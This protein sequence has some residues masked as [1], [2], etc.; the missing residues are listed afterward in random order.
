MK[1]MLLVFVVIFN[2][3]YLF[4]QT[5][6]YNETKTFEESD[7]T[8]KADVHSWGEIYLYNASN[9]WIGKKQVYKSTGKSFDFLNESLDY[10]DH[11]SWLVGKENIR[12]ILNRTLSRDEKRMIGDKE[13]ILNMYVN[14]TTGKIDDVCFDFFEDSP[15]RFIPISIYRK[16]ELDIKQNIQLTLTD[17]GRKLNYV[18]WWTAVTPGL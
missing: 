7:Y 13:I 9:A 5:D 14:S 1:R 11:A 4:S 3:L 2:S 15:Y 16:I 18:F 12:M 17:E 8:Y 6:Y 10:F